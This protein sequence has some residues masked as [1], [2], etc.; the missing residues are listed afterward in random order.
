MDYLVKVGLFVFF[1][2]GVSFFI[3]KFISIFQPYIA[4]LP[5]TSMLCQFGIFMGLNLFLSI[6]ISAFFVKQI[7]SFWK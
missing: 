6:I 3:E 4:S 1:V 7:L 5:I 2:A